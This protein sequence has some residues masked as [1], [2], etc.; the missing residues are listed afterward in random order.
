MVALLVVEPRVRGVVARRTAIA[1]QGLNICRLPKKL[2]SSLDFG[3]RMRACVLACLR[4]SVPVC[5]RACVSACLHS[6]K[7]AGSYAHRAGV[8]MC[9]CVCAFAR[10]RVFARA[11]VHVSIS[12]CMRADA[13]LCECVRDRLVGWLVES[14]GVF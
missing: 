11:C 1:N 7:S 4:A 10:A 5:L 8:H 3:A 14:S 9:R 6:S 2:N 12:V 13:S